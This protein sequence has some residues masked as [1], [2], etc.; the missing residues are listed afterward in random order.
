MLFAVY[1]PVTIF[2]NQFYKLVNSIKLQNTKLFDWIIVV[3]GQNKI[4]QNEIDFLNNLIPNLSITVIQKEFNTKYEA[5]RF[6][7]KKLDY[8]YVIAIDNEFV[9][10][11][12]AVEF[13]IN[14]WKIIE[15]NK[16]SIIE[17]R[18]LSQNYHGEILFNK[19]DLFKDNNYLEGTWHQFHLKQKINFEALPSWD[20]KYLKRNLNLDYCDQIFF[21]GFEVKTVN[22]WSSIGL[23]GNTRIVKM[24]LKIQSKS[25]EIKQNIDHNFE[26]NNLICF[27]KINKNYFFYN[28]IVFIK[29]FIK[30][31]FFIKT[32][33]IEVLRKNKYISHL[34]NRT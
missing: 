2:D 31:I 25:D 13:V 7:F 23:I 29:I 3:Y 4:K 27:L 22:I 32:K 11:D 14:Q 6:V 19:L 8:D 33:Y 34:I 18:G 17:I 12:G 5:T 21:K 16:S 24:V 9:L 10:V 1:T 26:I 30:I 15:K 20:L 28:P